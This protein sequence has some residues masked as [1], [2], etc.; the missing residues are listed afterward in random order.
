MIHRHL[1]YMYTIQKEYGLF[2]SGGGGGGVSSCAEPNADFRPV[3]SAN[4][5][6]HETERTAY[7]VEKVVLT[8]PR[9]SPKCRARFV[10]PGTFDLEN[11]TH[12][13]LS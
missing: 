11:E 5:T 3:L 1:I 4:E 12:M 8:A 6:S 2:F 10:N 13:C 7:F 9:T